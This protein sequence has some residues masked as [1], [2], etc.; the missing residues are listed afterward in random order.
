[1]HHTHS[2]SPTPSNARTSHRSFTSFTRH[3]P[4]KSTN[5]EDHP[6]EV[7]EGGSPKH[8]LFIILLITLYLHTHLHFTVRSIRILPIRQLQ[9]RDTQRP[10]IALPL[11]FPVIHFRRHVPRRA[12][13]SVPSRARC[14]QFHSQTKIA[15][16]NHS[17]LGDE[18]IVRLDVLSHH[19][20]HL[21]PT[22]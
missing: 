5:S 14:G 3:L 11:C 4:T 9:Q 22:L 20:H 17:L 18:Q 1:M 6:E 12:A 21:I 13:C 10:H 7:S 15:Q 2:H 8:T 19:L 16:F